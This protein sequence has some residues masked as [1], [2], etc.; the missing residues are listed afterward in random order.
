MEE[1]ASEAVFAVDTCR[2]E[3]TPDDGIHSCSSYFDRHRR[4]STPSEEAAV[5]ADTSDSCWDTACTDNRLAVALAW[6]NPLACAVVDGGV[7]D[8]GVGGGGGGDEVVVLD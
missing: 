4:R 5:A 6:R 7:D 3:S 8:G 1:A 2:R